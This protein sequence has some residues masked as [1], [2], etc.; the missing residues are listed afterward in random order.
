MTCK[1]CIHYEVC[2]HFIEDKRALTANL[3]YPQECFKDKTLFL[4]LPCKVG[5]KVYVISDTRVETATI[6]K[7][8]I[9]HNNEIDVSISFDCCDVGCDGCPFA[10][11]SHDSYSGEWFCDGEYGN[12]MIRSSDFNKTIFLTR[13]EA[14]NALKEKRK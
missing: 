1:D 7:I 13:E 3:T 10:M 8:C 12:F 6:D 11:W 4:E 9:S 5:D 2:E 14:E